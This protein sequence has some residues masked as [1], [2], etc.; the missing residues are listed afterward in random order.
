MVPLG[1][2]DKT[3]N[4]DLKAFKSKDYRDIMITCKKSRDSSERDQKM[5]LY[6]PGCTFI[7]YEERESKDKSDKTDRP[8]ISINMPPVTSGWVGIA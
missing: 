7:P 2:V 4:E 1:F 3:V 5:T 6:A 8:D